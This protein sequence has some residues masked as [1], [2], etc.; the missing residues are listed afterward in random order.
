[1]PFCISCGHENAD[2]A[3]F[4]NACGQQIPTAPPPTQAA[5]SPPNPHPP[6]PSQGSSRFKKGCLVVLAILGV[7]VLF[8]VIV[9]LCAP[10]VP[11]EERT[12][13]EMERATREAA[14]SATK[15]AEQTTKDA[16][17]ALQE[18]TKEAVEAQEKA[19]KEAE[20]QAKETEKAR[21]EY[22]K[23][24]EK[25]LEEEIE[26]GLGHRMEI[27]SP[28]PISAIAVGAAMSCGLTTE[29][30]PVCW[31]F[32]DAYRGLSGQFKSISAGAFHVCGI[33]VDDTIGCGGFNETSTSWGVGEN[34]RA[35]QADP[36]AGSFKSVSSGNSHTCA[37]KEDDSVVCWGL[38]NYGQAT[39]P[40]GLF[41]SISAGGFQTCGITLSEEIVCWGDS[42]EGRISP[43]FGE[44]VSVDSGRASTCGMITDGTLMCW[45][46]DVDGHTSPPSEVF[47]SFSTSGNTSCGIKKSGGMEC[48][49]DK[50]NG[51]TDLPD[52]EF[53]TVSVGASHACGIRTDG[54][55]VC[56]GSNDRGAVIVPFEGEPIATEQP[57]AV[58][59]ET[60]TR[61]PVAFGDDDYTRSKERDAYY[62]GGEIVPGVYRTAGPKIRELGPC[63]FA[64]MK[65]GATDPRYN[66]RHKDEVIEM[67]EVYGRAEVVIV[68]GG[69]FT[70]NCRQWTPVEGEATEEVIRLATKEMEMAIE[71]KRRD[72]DLLSCDDED[73]EGGVVGQ[74]TAI[75]NTSIKG[76]E[77]QTLLRVWIDG[78][79]VN[80]ICL[81]KANLDDGFI[82]I[83]YMMQKEGEEINIWVRPDSP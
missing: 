36:P 64:T 77:G 24:L 42:R 35:G 33:R 60:P 55:V 66:R 20:E 21:E 65:R 8:V 34:G 83:Q 44:F 18:Q 30:T 37:I 80:V 48:W 6:A 43:P 62:V 17:K 70:Y 19:T 45:G 4:C 7:F 68:S 39:P 57:T 78:D 3:R 38:D 82:M 75:L 56:W 11:E 28:M 14:E 76:L 15:V 63:V 58:P 12:R 67:W 52:G 41:R 32:D 29:G 16:G 46:S 54:K 72:G 69:F 27:E 10:D 31:G 40:D 59:N 2:T 81:A 22:D 71:Q 1:M 49:G 9:N 13:Q 61:E 51:V 53:F 50:F 23:R 47:D 73:L 25:A 26:G 74:A 79:T 5:P